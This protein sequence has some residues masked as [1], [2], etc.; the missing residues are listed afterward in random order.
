MTTAKADD[1]ALE[2][3]W[4]FKVHDD[5]V[6]V[7]QPLITDPADP[8]Y[9]DPNHNLF[10]VVCKKRPGVVIHSNDREGKHRV[11][12]LTRGGGL[13]LGA[14]QGL[15]QSNFLRN[16]PWE[17]LWVSTNLVEKRKA[18][19]LT[20][21]QTKVVLDELERLSGYGPPSAT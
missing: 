14:V 12:C 15:K 2:V 9:N 17:I 7:D 16:R 13:P 20:R 19:R 4:F 10:A 3:V 18:G 21:E 5:T 11:W 1:S 8:H 6:K